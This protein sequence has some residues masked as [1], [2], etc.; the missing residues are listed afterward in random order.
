MA[1]MIG[2][3]ERRRELLEAELRRMAA[4]LPMLGVERSWLTG[5]LARGE[6]DVGSA[7][8]LAL[9]RETDEPFRRRADF[10]VSHLQ[11]RVA[12]RF[13]VYTPAEFAEL[14]AR[15]PILRRALA[16]NA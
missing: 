12:T 7:L 15:D 11:P 5:D 13:W 4:E 9:V 6:V 8:E 14:G 2:F 10:F 3:A 1:V 16:D